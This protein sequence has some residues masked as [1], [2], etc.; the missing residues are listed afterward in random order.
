MKQGFGHR[1]D[2]GEEAV[3]SLMAQEGEFPFAYNAALGLKI[4][5]LPYKAQLSTMFFFLPDSIPAFRRFT[6]SPVPP[7]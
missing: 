1:S 2:S 5:A 6:A 4:L 7:L 3:V